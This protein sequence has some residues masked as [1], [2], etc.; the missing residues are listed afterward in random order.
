MKLKKIIWA[1]DGSR[2]SETALDYAKYIAGKSGAEI[3][4]VHVV[5]MPVQLLFDNISES[6]EEIKKWRLKIEDN[7]AKRFDEVKEELQKT[8]IKFDGVILKG[9]PS[10]KIKEFA[11]RKKA[12]L[13]VMGKHGHGFFESM[14]AGSETVR[15]L[16]SSR[17]PVLSIKSKNNAKAEFKNILVPIDLSEE[18]DSALTY[19]LNVAQLTGAKVTV[20]FVLRLDMYAQDLPA[21][22]LELVIEQ[23]MKS[24]NK[25]ASQL[26]KKFES[27]RG[28]SRNIQ[29]NT[30]VIHGMSEGVTI[31]QYATKKNI[32]L[33]VI[34][35]H[36]RTGVTRF[37]LGSVTERVV[38][39]AQC[40]VL[41]MR[42]EG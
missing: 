22:A 34:H 26:K 6:K 23:S 32:D 27:K 24:L 14:L 10:D 7:A 20:I 28:A 13:L 37:L 39:S 33:I 18:S 41:A 38:S 5:P 2:E 16:K 31:S 3:L 17:V 1:T 30:E 35:T 36:G 11:T 29:M 42:P 19:A 40:S 9:V 12:D 8:G 25:R 21:G 4:G 15:V